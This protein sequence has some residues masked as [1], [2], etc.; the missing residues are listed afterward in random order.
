[1][2]SVYNSYSWV[3]HHRLLKSDSLQI[4]TLPVNIL[5][6]FP[7]NCLIEHLRHFQSP[8]SIL[9]RGVQAEHMVSCQR[10][11]SKVVLAYLYTP[12]TPTLFLTIDCRTVG[13]HRLPGLRNFDFVL[14]FFLALLQTFIFGI[15]FKGAEVF[16]YSHWQ[17]LYYHH[18]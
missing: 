4:P 9:N 17:P 8:S 7:D 13:H 15:F 11:I 6:N 2:I 18:L 3:L 16:D 12:W 10:R 1:M 5:V 14:V